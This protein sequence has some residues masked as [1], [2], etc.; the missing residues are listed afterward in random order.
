ML[1][2][3]PT[4]YDSGLILYY[5]GRYVS[6]ECASKNQKKNNNSF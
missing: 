4:P 6:S 2:Y 3:S 1:I 5:I